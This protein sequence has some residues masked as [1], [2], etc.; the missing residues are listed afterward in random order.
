MST[1]DDRVAIAPGTEEE[2]RYY[3][4]EDPKSG[5]TKLWM[6]VCDE[7]WRQS[8]VCEGMYDWAADWLLSIIGRQPYAP[9]LRP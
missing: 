2:P 7:G 4:V 1:S 5:A 8:I 3:R 6:I 9:G